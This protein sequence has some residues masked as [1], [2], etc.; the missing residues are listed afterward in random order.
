M[1]DKVI[2]IGGASGYWGESDMAVPQFLADG[3]VDYIV[4]D[5]LAEVTMSILARA[6]SQ[7]ANLGYATDFVTGVVKP[8]LTALAAAGVRLISNAG[9]VNPESCAQAIREL[10]AEQGLSLSVAVVAGDDVLPQLR[11]APEGSFT[12]MFSGESM[13]PLDRIASANAYLGAFPIAEALSSG[14]DIVITGRCVDS[15]VTLAACIHEFGWRREDLDRLAAGS[16]V[17]HLIECGP[18][19]TGGNFTDWTTVADSLHEVGYPIANVSADGTCVISKP[20][21]TGGVV[22]VGTVGEQLLYEIGDP[23]AYRLPDVTCDFTDVELSELAP[24]QVLVTGAKGLAAPDT[25][26]VSVTWADGWRAGSIFFYVGQQ[27]AAKARIFAEEA[28][29]RARRKLVAMKAPYFDDV[30]IEVIGDE[31]HWGAHSRYVRSREVAVKVACRHQDKR[32]VALLLKELSGA[33]L[34]APPGLCV[35]TGTRAKPSPVIRLFSTVIDR[36]QVSIRVKDES[37]EWTFADARPLENQALPVAPIQISTQI[38]IPIP[39]AQSDEVRVEVPLERLA[40]AR[41]GDKGDKANIGVMARKSVYL[42]WIAQT[43]T[44]EYV[45]NRFEHFMTS[46]SID[47]YYLPGIAALNFVIHNALGGGGVASLRNDPQAKCYAQILLDTPIAI[48]SPLITPSV[49]HPPL[50]PPPSTGD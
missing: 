22:T 38:P 37:R 50:T 14:A 42:P 26:K 9:G 32:A 33:A 43:L 34:G 47:R 20:K 1:A 18:Q 10:I 4:F 46:P 3:G 41:S 44:P 48:P 13:P 49:T 36:S 16:L 35:F 15:A 28:L 23:G 27:A 21:N 31:S 7:D 30:A 17:G 6:R 2:R 11:E 19:A 5:Y 29:L 8:H 25:Y 45:A 40:W 12:E 39:D 24:D